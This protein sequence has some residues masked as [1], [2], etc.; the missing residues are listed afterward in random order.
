[1]AETV[2]HVRRSAAAAEGGAGQAEQAIAAERS[3]ADALRDR[4]DAAEQGRREA[5][6]ALQTAE[7]RAAALEQAETERAA[8]SRW[9]RLRDAL[10]RQ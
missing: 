7:A 6:D 1:M 3:R 10:R 4:L 8:R 2:R 5:Q 9:Q